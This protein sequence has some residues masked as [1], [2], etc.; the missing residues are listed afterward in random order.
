MVAVHEGLVT[1][2]KKN[3]NVQLANLRSWN[4]LSSDKL[5]KDSK[6]IVGFL[7]SKEMKSVTLDPV[8]PAKEVAE[9]SKEK[10]IPVKPDSED[11][12]PKDEKKI[13]E[14]EEKAVK[15]EE[16]KDPPVVVKE[17][18]KPLI[19]GQGYFRKHFE[20]QVRQYP[21]SKDETVA[22]GI[23]K[24]TS[25]WEDAKY[26]LL[27]DKVQP[28]TIVKVINPTTNKAVYA[29]VLGEMA[30][31]RQNEGYT[32]RISNAAASALDITEQDKFIVKVVY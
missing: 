1:V 20:Q 11:I 3:N 14:A 9:K 22:S 29:K 15:Q 13:A 5:K 18:R 2:S 12:T 4:G 16:K 17:I 21:V 24:T 27:M 7:I 30:G 23:F 32:I 25:G 6:L 26:Y 19:E 31:I 10:P 28:G 8:T